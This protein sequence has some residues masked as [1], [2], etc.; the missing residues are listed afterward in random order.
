MEDIITEGNRL[1]EECRRAFCEQV[2]P[3]FAMTKGDGYLVLPVLLAVAMLCSEDSAAVFTVIPDDV[4]D[5]VDDERAQSEPTRNALVREGVFPYD[6][7]VDIA[8]L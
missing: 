1:V 3:C 6:P 4:R 7:G 2:E 5:L 8:A